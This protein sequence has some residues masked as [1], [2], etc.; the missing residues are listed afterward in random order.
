MTTTTVSTVVDAVN[1]PDGLAPDW[2]AID[3]DSCRTEVE[4]LRRRI[5]TASQDGDWA[6]VRNLQKLLLR[7]RSNVL[8]SVRQVTQRNAG[9]STAGVDGQVALTS[10]TR[11]ELAARILS[12]E[13]KTWSPLPVRR[14]HIL[15]AGDKT[16]L[17]PLGIPVVMDRCLQA[18]VRNALEPEW[19]AQFEARSY[20]FRPGRGCHDAIEAIFAT[21]GSR[22]AQRLWILDA[23]LKAAFDR[24]D[25]QHLMSMIG[26][27]PGAGLI[28]QWLKAGVIDKGSFFSSEEG[29]PQ[30]GVISPC[31]LNIALH[32]LE[33]AAGVRYERSGGVKRLTKRASPVVVRYADDLLALCHTRD[34]AEQVQ[35]Q[36]AE[37][38]RPRGLAFNDDKT[39]I[40][41]AETGFDFL[42]F[43]IRRY[44][45][46][47]LIK[48]SKTAITRIKQRLRQEIRASRGSTALALIA[49]INPIVRG[50]AAY[51]RTVVSSEIFAKLDDY[52][53]RL[54][55]QWA[56]W[57]HRN[58][59][60]RWVTARYF[61]RFNPT[62]NDRWVFGDRHTGAYMRRFAWTNIV[63]H[64]MVAGTASVDDPA[65]ANYWAMRR[66]RPRQLPL[67]TYLL[68]QQ[69][70]ECPGCG[71][72]LIDLDRPPQTPQ[73]WEHWH[74][75][76]RVRT[77]R[78][79]VQAVA[80]GRP[81]QI[82]R[83]ITHLRCRPQPRSGNTTMHPALPTGL[84]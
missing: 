2:D 25:H 59:P 30:G 68:N 65:L 20:G 42:G 83:T 18:V 15:K 53:W 48:P 24:I 81:D 78:Y 40:V 5:F 29:T 1:G 75:N 6:R 70:R 26:S 56:L 66:R 34:Q 50:W 39:S 41:D 77:G 51:Y 80:P 11:A 31:L 22:S 13:M 16:K 60:K 33:H 72:P 38:L 23:D 14:V 63:R 49:T 67:D 62:R 7:S 73:E 3:W 54:T 79:P 19:E 9:R 36:V 37:W 71:E 35:A 64:T 58:K 52:L 32:G 27:F 4:R 55:Y 46:K 8:L 76:V 21:L 74:R 43:N 44:H 45:G 17:R 84:A 28:W 61:G 69:D 47:L 57:Q 82:R 10:T 12:G